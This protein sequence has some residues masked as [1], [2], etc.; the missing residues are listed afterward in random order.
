MKV[1]TITKRGLCRIESVP[2]ASQCEVS[3]TVFLYNQMPWS[4]IHVVS[5]SLAPCK[6]LM[7]YIPTAEVST[8]LPVPANIY[9]C[10]RGI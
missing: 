7:K 6:S 4:R 5:P 8:V 1:P 9:Q 10:T 2:Q 3:S